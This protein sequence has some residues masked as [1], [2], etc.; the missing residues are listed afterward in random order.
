M[1]GRNFVGQQFV[2]LVELPELIRDDE[3]F[4][5][6][7]VIDNDGYFLV[8]VMLKNG[9]HHLTNITDDTIMDKYS[10]ME[11]LSENLW[12]SEN[13]RMTI[14]TKS[15]ENLIPIMYKHNTEFKEYQP[16]NITRQVDEVFP[17]KLADLIFSKKTQR[18]LFIRYVNACIKIDKI[19]YY[20]NIVHNIRYNDKVWVCMVMKDLT[21]DGPVKLFHIPGVHGVCEFNDF[22]IL[23]RKEG[24]IWYTNERRYTE[25]YNHVYRMDLCEMYG[26]KMYTEENYKKGV[27]NEV[28][29][30]KIEKVFYPS[31]LDEEI[32]MYFLHGCNIFSPDKDGNLI[33]KRDKLIYRTKCSRNGKKYYERKVFAEIFEGK[34]FLEIMEFSPYERPVK[35]YHIP[36]LLLRYGRLGMPVHKHFY[37][38]Y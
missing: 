36:T 15:P 32:P 26:T 31:D 6:H 38:N 12:S 35:F 11:Y 20:F 18:L 2:K 21:N 8:A 33:I 3:H 13:S 5:R 22:K 30:P 1:Y 29:L 23:Q 28:K 25:Y 10:S 9:P 14:T 7:I 16:C 34:G 24:I 37:Y 17:Q 4:M 19:C 27:Y